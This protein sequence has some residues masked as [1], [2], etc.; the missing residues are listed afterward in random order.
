MRSSGHFSLMIYNFILD[1]LVI[2]FQLLIIFRTI[3]SEK[4]E[5]FAPPVKCLYV[6]ISL[7]AIRSSRVEKSNN[8]AQECTSFFCRMA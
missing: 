7:I 3:T 2:V 5:F 4:L 8:V 1:Q 6:H